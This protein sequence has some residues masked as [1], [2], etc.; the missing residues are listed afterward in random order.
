MKKKILF[1]LHLP[2]PLHGASVMGKYI[3]ESHLINESFECDFINYSA[4]KNVE[5]VGVFSLN[6]MYFLIKNIVIIIKLH[7][8]KKF[9]L[10]Y[11]TP[12]SQGLGFYRDFLLVQTLKLLGA[13][14]ILH[15]HNKSGKEWIS[16][17]YNRWLLSKFYRNLDI[18][19]LGKELY[20]EKTP[21]I[22]EN[23]VHYCPN[24]IVVNDFDNIDSIFKNE[25]KY[26]FLFLSNYIKEKGI[27]TL[28]E[29]CSILKRKGFLF[30]CDFIGAW[31]NVNSQDVNDNIG[32]H[33]LEEY[34]NFLGPKYNMDKIEFFR[35]S[36]CLIFPTYYEGETFGLVLLEAMSYGLPC[37]STFEGC[38]PSIIDDGETGFCVEAKNAEALA[39][40]MAWM[41]NN[42][43]SAETMGKRGYEKF[44]ANYTLN[45]FE[46]RLKL[47]LEDCMSKV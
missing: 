13:K 30:Q 32:E 33:G 22:K 42:P 25:T 45:H 5:D 7:F 11:I 38:I 16:K 31:K 2:P 44:L 35:Q 18:I 14:I 43:R 10:Y 9:D 26:K 20:S 21:F 37:I 47:I 41:M 1:I 3:Q 4:S 23:N 12:T 28:I 36:N 24:G 46:Q 40:K 15:F 34:V 17:G 29:A 27:F 6:K 39:E 19:L 8:Q